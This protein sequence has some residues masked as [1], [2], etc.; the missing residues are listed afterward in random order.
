[1]S[2]WRASEGYWSKLLWCLWNRYE[3]FS[4]SFCHSLLSPNNYYAEKKFISQYNNIIL[5]GNI[6]TRRVKRR[7]TNV[8][9]ERTRTRQA[10]LVVWTV[11]RAQLNLTPDKLCALTVVRDSLGTKPRRYNHGTFLSPRHLFVLFLCYN[12]SGFV[13]W[14]VRQ[15]PTTVD[16]EPFLKSCLLPS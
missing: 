1:M 8:N 13:L 10:K 3:W 16:G 6:K 15:T 4:L 11:P 9:R 7:A 12:L 5:Q 14:L 2:G